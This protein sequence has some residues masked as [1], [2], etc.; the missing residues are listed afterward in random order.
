MSEQPEA[1]LREIDRNVVY[2][3]ACLDELLPD[4]HSVRIIWAYVCALDLSS[5]LARIRAVD[6]RPGRNAN[7]PRLLLALWLYATTD[8]VGS[9]RELDRLCRLHL[10]YRWLCG[11]CSVNYHSLSDFRTR[12]EQ[13]LD[14]LLVTH[15]SALWHQGLIDLKCVAQD[16]MRT[17]ADAGAASFRREPTIQDCQQRVQEQLDALKRQQGETNNEVSKRQ[18]AA[19]ERAAREKQT[20][21]QQALEV[22]RQQ[23]AAR[24]QRLKL[25]PSEAKKKKKQDADGAADEDAA[26]VPQGRGSTTDPQARKMKMPDGGYRPAYNVQAATTTAGGIIVAV[27]VSNQGGDGGLMAPMLERIQR[28]Y[29]EAVAAK[30]QANAAGMAAVVAAV[31]VVSVLAAAAQDPVVKEMLVDGGFNNKEQI[32]DAHERGTAVYAPL[33][34]EAKDL[35]AGLDP[36]QAKAKDKAGMAA[37][38]ERMGSEEGKQKYKLRASTA[39]WVNA[40]MRNRGLYR[41]AVRGLVKVRCVVLLHALVH[42]LMQTRRLCAQKMPGRDFREILRAQTT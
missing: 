21:L 32:E 13:Q 10:A 40:G 19:R 8:G 24:E 35:K 11:D 41:V 29:S 23:Q 9:A 14:E 1:R 25:H 16:G 7:D 26:A 37:L 34:N 28:S 6:G 3:P 4:D 38:R 12:H 17:R 36:Y 42:N 39:E 18:Q 27:D 33:K 2:P 15:V 22:A 5:F 20:R 31:A 30:N